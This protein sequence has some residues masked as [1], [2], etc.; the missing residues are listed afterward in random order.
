[1]NARP[2]GLPRVSPRIL[3]TLIVAAIVGAN[4]FVVAFSAYALY[5]SRQQYELRARDLTG[6]MAEAIAQS[7]SNSIDKIDLARLAITDEWSASWPN[8]TNSTKIK[9]ARAWSKPS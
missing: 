3:R 8:S 7:L 4:V 5:E 6:N 1:M 2:K 9:S